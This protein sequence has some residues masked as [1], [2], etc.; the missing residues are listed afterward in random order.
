MQR[1]W[2][3]GMSGLLWAAFYQIDILLL[4][5]MRGP[6]DVATYMVPVTVIGALHLLPIA[7][8]QLFMQARYHWWAESDPRKLRSVYAGIQRAMLA[9]GAVLCV[10]VAATASVVVPIVFGDGFGESVPVLA[11]MSL[12]IPFRWVGSGAGAVMTTKENIRR[13][14]RQQAVATLV[15]VAL[16]AAL[17]PFWGPRGAAV[18]TVVGEA[19]LAALYLSGVRRFFR[20]PDR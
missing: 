16:N 18:S 6:G 20:H 1:A 8:N 5:G 19:V 7:I 4:G 14:V 13:K 17:I 15:N 11:V 2:P 12:A 3:F 10:A 9:A